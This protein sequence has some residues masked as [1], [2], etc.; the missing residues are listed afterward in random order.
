MTRDQILTVLS[1]MPHKVNYGGFY[2]N[3]KVGFPIT[4][5]VKK[6]AAQWKQKLVVVD[7]TQTTLEDLQWLVNDKETPTTF[8]F[9]NFNRIDN[10]GKN[11]VLT[12]FISERDDNLNE[13]SNVVF[14]MAIDNTQYD[15]FSIDYVILS[16]GMKFTVTE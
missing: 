12:N 2:F 13:N 14:G 4:E 7:C 5:F 6:V 16:K 3:H 10:E 11:F 8:F 15:N 1:K 9:E